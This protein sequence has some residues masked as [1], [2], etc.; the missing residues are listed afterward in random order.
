MAESDRI[1]CV[2]TRTGQVGDLLLF[3]PQVLPLLLANSHRATSLGS[4]FGGIGIVVTRAG[5]IILILRELTA[6]CDHIAALHALSKLFIDGVI[7]WARVFHT[8]LDLILPDIRSSDIT[9]F[10]EG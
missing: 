8:H 3:A 5:I 6:L 9:N 1:L 7:T 4:H 2:V 10:A